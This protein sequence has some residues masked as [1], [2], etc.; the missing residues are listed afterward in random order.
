[1][2]PRG[3]R[4]C[5]HAVSQNDDVFHGDAMLGHDVPHKSVHI[6]DDRGEIVRGAA[7]ARRLAVAARVPGEHGDIVES[8]RVY[9]FLPAAGVLMTAV[10]EHERLVPGAGWNPGAV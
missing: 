2:H 10:E 6:L 5:A 3:H 4:H 9:R 7:L 1:M 8:E